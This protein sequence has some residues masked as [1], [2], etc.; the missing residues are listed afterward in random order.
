MV[1]DHNKTF[2]KQFDVCYIRT[3]GF[4]Y[5]SAQWSITLYSWMINFKGGPCQDRHCHNN[6]KCE[7]DPVLKSSICLCPVGYHD[8]NCQSS[9]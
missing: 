8:T 2:G 3:C 1:T 9:M 4:F 7:A 5:K 6:G